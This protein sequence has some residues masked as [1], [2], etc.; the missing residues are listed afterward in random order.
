M[1]TDLTD[2][3]QVFLITNGRS[4]FPYCYESIE[5]QKNVKLKVAIHRDMT[6]LDANR[7]ILQDCTSPY[8]VRID[9]DMILHPQALAYMWACV[10]N[11]SS[12][13]ALRGFRLWEPY[14]DKVVKGIKVYRFDIVKEIGFNISKI[15]KIDKVFTK[16]AERKGYII[17]YSDD[18]VGIHSCTKFEEHLRY[19][20][21]R[22]EDNNKDF[23]KEKA[24]MK[25][26]IEG[27]EVPLDEQAKLAGGFLRKLNK[28]KKT[29]FY[30][31]MR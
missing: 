10:R 16:E 2:K 4:T 28:K 20:I 17:E 19:A 23:P 21:M 27:Y 26:H 15:G 14:S 1:A 31:F 22:G 8:F 30:K 24:W 9:D 11:Q 3:L 29:S 12:R 18:V 25:E 7:L 13:I 5:Q 6:W